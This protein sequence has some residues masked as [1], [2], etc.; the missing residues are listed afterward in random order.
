MHHLLHSVCSPRFIRQRVTEPMPSIFSPYII[1]GNFTLTP[2]E[3]KTPQEDD[4]PHY[5]FAEEPLGIP[6]EEV[7]GWFQGGRASCLGP[8]S[9]FKVEVKLGFGTT[10]FEACS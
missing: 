1:A 7:C 4:L 3:E 5:I 8:D 6:A 10:Y 9:R 2:H